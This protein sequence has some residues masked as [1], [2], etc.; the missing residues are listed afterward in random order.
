MPRRSDGY[1]LLSTMGSDL[2]SD[3][4]SGLASNG[5]GG[6]FNSSLFDFGH[7]AQSSNNIKV[8]ILHCGCLHTV[9]IRVGS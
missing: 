6:I 8:S 7:P 9:L 2:G 4:M 1:N 3:Y 5:P